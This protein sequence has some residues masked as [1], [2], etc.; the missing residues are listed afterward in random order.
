MP[1]NFDRFD[2]LQER[3]KQVL[4]NISKLQAQEK[5]L[6]N[7]LDNSNLSSEEKQQI[8]N[9]INEISQMRINMYASMKDIYSYYQQ[10]ISASRNTLG[11]EMIAIDILENELNESKKRLNALEDDKYNK[12]RLVEINTYYGKRY[13]AHTTIL[14]LIVI[15]CIPII[16]LSFLVNRGVLQTNLYYFLTGIVIIITVILLGY[17]IIDISN[18]DNMNFDEYNWYFKKSDAPKATEIN[19]DS[20]NINLD[21]WSMPTFTCIGADCCNE[22]STYD[23]NLNKCIPISQIQ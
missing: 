19:S 13:A 21:P 2:N 4:D 6:Y 15:M 9:K 14:K 23:E 12:L 20:T 17:Q 16:T 10:N 3:N 11:Q 5:D 1:D 22:N 8:I 18:R 7:S